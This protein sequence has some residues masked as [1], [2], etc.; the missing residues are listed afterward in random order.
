MKE[1]YRYISDRVTAY[2]LDLLLITVLVTCL[3]HNSITNPFY[4]NI[5]DAQNEYVAVYKQEMK[6]NKLSNSKEVDRFFKNVSK[7]F[8][9]Y[10]IRNTF[11]LTLWTV[12]LT[13][14]YFGL[15]AWFNDGQTLG[16]KLSKLKVV[17]NK[18]GKSASLFQLCIR[19]IFGGNAFLGGCNTIILLNLFLPLIKN[20]YVY[21]LTSISLSMLAYLIDFIFIVL[22]LFKKNGRTLDD[23]V[24][25]TKV[26]RY[27]KK[28][29]S[30]NE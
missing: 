11:A 4:N 2:I 12:I 16:K 10:N 15:F 17:N 5:K 27:S 30:N 19:N 20:S 18:D 22:F 3:M 7:E 21:M 14:F 1:R 26:I 13:V 9:T 8:R 23:L 29:V 24:G 25:G 6:E 28:S